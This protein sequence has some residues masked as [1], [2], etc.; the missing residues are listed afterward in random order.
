[1]IYLYAHLIYTKI[2]IAFKNVRLFEKPVPVRGQQ[3]LWEWT[4]PLPE[5]ALPF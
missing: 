3:Y 5:L 4:G 1:M 2:R